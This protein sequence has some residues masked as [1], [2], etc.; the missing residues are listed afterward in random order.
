MTEEVVTDNGVRPDALTDARLYESVRTK[1]VLAFLFDAVFIAILT[2]SAGFM[3]LVLGIFTL[4]LGW[5]L[6]PLLWP[7]LALIYCAF[8]LGGPASA[9]PGMRAV[10]LEMR[11]LN[12]E[13][14]TAVLAAVHVILYYASVSLLSPLVVLFSLITDRKRLLHDIVLGTVVIN[15]TVEN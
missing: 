1:R 13:P 7:F 11:Q 9:T 5:L 15:R 8:T 4:G 6:F 3:V 14:M 10:G 12:G 2:V